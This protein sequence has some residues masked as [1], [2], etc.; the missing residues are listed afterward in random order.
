MNC[1]LGG[2]GMVNS[3]QPHGLWPTRL[4]C[5]LKFSR[6]EYW[7]EMPFPTLKD[8][9]DPGVEPGSPALAS[10]FFTINTCW[11]GW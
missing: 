11:A 9:P 2:S 8:L 5:S 6:Q 3:L 10:G 4:L 1:V 7:N